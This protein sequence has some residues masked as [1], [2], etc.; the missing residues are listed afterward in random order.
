MKTGNRPTGLLAILGTLT[1]V[2]SSSQPASAIDDGPRTYWKARQG[3]Q[4]VGFQYLRVDM[5]SSGAEQFDPAFYTYPNSDT[6]GNLFIASYA[7]H[8]T[9]FKRP[10]SLALNI[11]GGNLDADL[12]A[13]EFLPPGSSLSQSSSGFG[14]P[15]VQW[16]I[17]LLG[18]PPIRSTYDQMNYEP[19]FTLDLATLVALPVGEYDSDQLVNLGLNR[20]YGRVA[21][22]MKYH[23]GPSNPGRRTSLELT[24]S[25]WLFAENDDFLGSKLENDPMWQI[26]AHLTRDFTPRFYGSVDLLY[27]GGFQSSIDG[28]QVGEEVNIGNLGFTLHYQATDNFAVRAGY[29]SN[30]FGDSDLNNSVL[31]I[32]FV[33]GWHPT[34]ENSKKLQGGH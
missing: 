27:R 5:N 9:L 25:V 12:N 10:S 28:T 11:M 7:P 19:S 32:M 30:V 34:L 31:R 13:P 22:P 23:F 6:E 8:F 18:A 3:A 1:I 2:L 17:N 15:N 26:E 20:W 29:S 21:L 4:V 16:V 14:D 33:Y 24:P